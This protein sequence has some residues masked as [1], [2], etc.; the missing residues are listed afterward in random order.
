MEVIADYNAQ[1]ERT[2]GGENRPPMPLLRWAEPVDERIDAPHET[3]RRCV[4]FS[5]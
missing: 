3:D 4:H 5:R 2:G 1:D